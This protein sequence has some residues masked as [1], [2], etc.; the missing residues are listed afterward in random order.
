M[1]THSG[2]ITSTRFRFYIISTRSM[3]GKT[4]KDWTIGAIIITIY[5][6]NSHA[7]ILFYFF[8]SHERLCELTLDFPQ[9]FQRYPYKWLH[10]QFPS[11]LKVQE[12]ALS[13]WIEQ[14]YSNNHQHHQVQLKLVIINFII[15][16]WTQTFPEDTYSRIR[17]DLSPLSLRHRSLLYILFDAW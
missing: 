12:H 3:P 9:A 14:K 1:F 13:W 17:N 2:T 16:D 15:F 7:L 5:K 11:S 6:L 4:N 10:S 8:F